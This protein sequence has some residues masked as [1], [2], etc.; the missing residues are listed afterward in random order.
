MTEVQEPRHKATQAYLQGLLRGEG[1]PEDPFERTVA[2]RFVGTTGEL[3]Q[4]SNQINA[5]RTQ[6][7]QMQTRLAQLVGEAD[8]LARLLAQ[9]FV[10]RQPAP[11]PALPLEE[12]RKTLGAD[13]V[14]AVNAQGT[15]LE[16]TEGK[17][18]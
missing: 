15:V 2:S 7:E 8:G 16:T 4:L 6:I 3:Q 14:D 11:A 12:L 13:R 10:Q 1:L 18:S 17:E 5:A 9:A